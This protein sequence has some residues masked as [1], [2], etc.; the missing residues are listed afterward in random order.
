MV[1]T[2][3]K[4]R[5]HSATVKPDRGT[6]ELLLAFTER[7]LQAAFVVYCCRHRCLSQARRIQK[8]M[9]WV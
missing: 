8:T 6:P 4:D 5:L 3:L 1:V 7:R 9:S 2:G